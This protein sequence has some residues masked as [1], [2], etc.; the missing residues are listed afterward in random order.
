MA[1]EK[2]S[3]M[4]AA[5][6]VS[7]ADLV[8]IVQTSTNKKST[9]VIVKAYIQA[10]FDSVYVPLTRTLTINGNTQ[11][12]SVDRTFDLAFTDLTDVPPSYTGEAGKLA[13]VKGD[14]SGLEF[15]PVAAGAFTPADLTAAGTDG[16]A[17]TDGTA[18]VNGAGTSIAQHVAD[19]T[20]NGYLLNTDWLAFANATVFTGL[21]DVPHSYSGQSG[22]VVSVKST[23]DA[24]EFT[25]PVTPA[26]TNAHY[27]TTQA[28]SGLSNEFSLGSLSSGILKQSVTSSVA[29][30]AIATAGTDYTALAF[31]TISVSGQSDVVADSAADTLTLVAGANVAITTDA[32][33]DTITLAATGSTGGA[34]NA[35]APNSTIAINVLSG[36]PATLVTK[37]ITYAAGDTVVLKI[38]GA[39]VND[40]TASRQYS[41]VFS[42]G[43]LT[44]TIAGNANISNSSTNRA[45]FYIEV[46]F[47]VKDTGSAWL[48]ARMQAST[49]ANLGTSSDLVTT[50]SQMMSQHSSSNLTGAQTTS[51]AAYSSANTATQSFELTAWT[52]EKFA[53][54][55]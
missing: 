24:L 30:P 35:D 20:H 6:S 41:F 33:T 25:T 7:D 29:T 17:V 14:E 2:I 49:E 16:I 36:A 13:A 53:S 11:D 47:G 37:S 54:N 39:I 23:E 27:V 3:A 22:K 50:R 31:K 1:D 34:L 28:E 32:S 38:W 10:A 45:K 9:W 48:L 43:T 18:A 51:V 42:L 21:E 15:I 44:A 26:P 8:P 40:S 4:P 46:C 52:I 5:S 19:A 12:L 55:P